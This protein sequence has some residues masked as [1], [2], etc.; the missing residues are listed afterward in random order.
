MI[1][2]PQFPVN[3]RRPEVWCRYYNTIILKKRDSLPLGTASGLGIWRSPCDP[4]A[5]VWYT[6][7]PISSVRLNTVRACRPTV[8]WCGAGKTGGNNGIVSGTW[9]IHAKKNMC[10]KLLLFLLFSCSF[11]HCNRT[12]SFCIFAQTTNFKVKNIWGGKA[13]PCLWLNPPMPAWTQR[14]LKHVASGG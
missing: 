3:H 12:S 1:I 8:R 2:Q 4:W 9:G 11:H 13:S 14:V 10:L 7:T 6:L 5:K